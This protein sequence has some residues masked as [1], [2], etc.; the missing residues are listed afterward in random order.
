PLLLD[1]TPHVLGAIRDVTQQR[2]AERERLLQV[3]HIRLQSEL[4]NQA[5][6]AILVRDPIGRV[7]SWNR[8]A[9]HLYG[10][11]EQEALGR[12]APTLLKTH[13]S[14]S[15]ATLD[16]VLE[17]E[18]QW[19]GELTHTRRDGSTVIVESR[20]IL[21]RDEAGQPHAILEINR[22]ITE[23]HR[24][25]QAE[26]IAHAETI[27]RLAFLQQVL[28]ALP[29]SVYLVHG[30]DARLL[31]ANRAASS[32][33]GAQWQ[34]DQ[35]IQ[36]FLAQNG[37]ELMDAQGR[38]LSLDQLA[39][40]RA[41]QK[42]ET[43]VQYQET[44]RHRDGS[45]LPVLVNALL[46]T[47][48]QLWNDPQR[49]TGQLLP[50]TEPVALVIHQDVTA[51]KEAEYLKDEF[52]GIAAHELRTPLAV[53]A[54]YADMLLTQTARGHGP[55]L[56]DWQQEALSE[57]KQGTA[58]L[59]TLTEDLLDV[60]RL[61]AGRLLLQRTA[62][63]IGALVQRVAAHMQQTTTRHQIE[64]HTTSHILV[65][66]IDTA[67]VEQ[68]LMNLIG[69][70]IKY[71]PDGGGISITINEETATRMVRISV[72]DRGIGIPKHQQ[73]Q[74]FGR[75]IRADNAL[76]WGISG[77]GLGLYLCREF[78]ERQGG[79]L[80]FE[81]VEG[82]GSTFFVTFPL[83]PDDQEESSEHTHPSL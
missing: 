29:S 34:M 26:Q 50:A 77:T 69:N 60:T 53:I 35:P 30:S 37:I 66:N 47:P 11:T 40:L 83:I 54:G 67:R 8:G 76:A 68:V 73:A 4:I 2:L 78:V 80:W 51:L 44:I 14:I 48:S 28:D 46:L 33:W 79:H 58:R 41:V 59:G 45:N 19:E 43:V 42:G 72:Q 82:A 63:D 15:H 62:G 56:A 75:F 25:A 52:V 36:E 70:A 81:S 57:I 16:T 6:D 3:Q 1:D 7:L 64:V 23:R 10:W 20:Q 71:S 9:E 12:V 55:S 32:F 18:G 22:D 39:T 31:L 17:H 74:I 65:A 27:E 5:H 13:A 21:M 61:Q 49:S 24:K 38:P